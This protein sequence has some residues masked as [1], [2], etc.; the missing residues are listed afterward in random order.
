MSVLR[1]QPNQTPA[2][3]PS[4]RE[5]LLRADRNYSSFEDLLYNSSIKS[6]HRADERSAWWRAISPAGQLTDSA[7]PLFVNESS[8]P[9][10]LSKWLEVSADASEDAAVFAYFSTCHLASQIMSVLLCDLFSLKQQWKESQNSQC[11]C[12]FMHSSNVNMFTQKG[13]MHLRICY[14]YARVER[15]LYLLGTFM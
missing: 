9:V 3:G 14:F 4:H 6:C 7:A 10:L 2:G 12:P 1:T 11:S 8:R 5:L 15:F 13:C